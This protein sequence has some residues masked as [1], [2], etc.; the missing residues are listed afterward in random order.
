MGVGDEGCPFAL[1]PVSGRILTHVYTL[2]HT[3]SPLRSYPAYHLPS[4]TVTYFHAL[5]HLTRAA[6]HEFQR[7]SEPLHASVGQSQSRKPS[8][9]DFHWLSAN[10]KS[11]CGLLSEVRHLQAGACVSR[12]V[13]CKPDR[14]QFTCRSHSGSTFSLSASRLTR[15]FV[16]SLR[17]KL[18]DLLHLPR[19]LHI[20][21][22]EGI[23]LH[24]TVTNSSYKFC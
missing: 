16:I 13:A 20:R 14:R 24:G 22:H 4:H 3:R 11:S 15:V 17:G 6:A 23:L 21:S 8:A 5:T 18:R 9:D 7:L 10:G 2:I 12:E 1:P 19:P